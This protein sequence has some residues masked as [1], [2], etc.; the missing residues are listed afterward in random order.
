MDT[1]THGIVGALA[2]RAFFAGTPRPSPAVIGEASGAGHAPIGRAAIVACTL[3]A[4]F[5]D[6]DVF[7]GPVA[8][9][10]L[11]MLEWHRGVTHSVVALPFW[12]LLLAAVAGPLGRWVKWESPPFWRRAVIFGAG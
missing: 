2:A 6:I 7:A 3:G 4:M 9:N 8:G 10:P 11:A 1:I 12:A 5:P